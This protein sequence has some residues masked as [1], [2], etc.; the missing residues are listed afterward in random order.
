MKRESIVLFQAVQSELARTGNGE[1]PFLLATRQKAPGCGDSLTM[2]IGREWSVVRVDEFISECKQPFYVAYVHPSSSDCPEVVEWG[3]TMM[4]EDSPQMAHQLFVASTGKVIQRKWRAD[5]AA[6]E[7]GERLLDYHVAA[8][9]TTP[10]PFVVNSVNAYRPVV[11][12][13]IPVD[14][15][16]AAIHLAVCAEVPVATAV[17]S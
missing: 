8:H 5:G 3:W 2:G 4:M 9:S 10:T 17:A 11:H 14:G 6:P 1:E 16:Y 13:D 15:Q 7:V 12:Q